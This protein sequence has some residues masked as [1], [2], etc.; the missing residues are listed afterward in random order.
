M[1]HQQPAFQWGFDMMAPQP[2]LL[3]DMST[4]FSDQFMLGDYPIKQSDPLIHIGANG[5][6]SDSFG[7]DDVSS[8][9]KPIFDLFICIIQC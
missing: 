8:D 4:P 3:S 9:G 7:L 1:E 6:Y 5:H 2:S